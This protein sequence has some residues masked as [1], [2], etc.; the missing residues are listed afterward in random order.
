L[1]LLVSRK[2]IDG[3]VAKAKEEGSR[4][5]EEEDRKAILRHVHWV[6]TT[7]DRIEEGSTGFAAVLAETRLNEEGVGCAPWVVQQCRKRRTLQEIMEGIKS[8]E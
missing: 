1:H 6:H 2:G 7:F 8:L 5:E 4:A 3:S